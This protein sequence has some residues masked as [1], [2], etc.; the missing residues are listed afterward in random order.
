MFEF[1]PDASAQIVRTRSAENQT[2]TTT[3]QRQPDSGDEG[4]WDIG[5]MFLEFLGFLGTLIVVVI[6]TY[7]FL[8]LVRFAF[9]LYAAKDLVYLKVTLPRADSKLDK[10]RETK[11]DFKE[12]VGIMSIVYKGLHKISAITF[13]ETIM[14]F[15]FQHSKMSLELV[16][17]EGQVHFFVVSYRSY[18][19]II[20]QQVT[21][22]YPDAEVRE[23]P[24]EKYFH[25]KPRGYTL[26]AA[27]VAKEYDDIYPIK[28]F[29]YF[30]DDPLSSFTNAFGGLNPGDKAVVQI[31]LKPV[32]ASWNRHA[33]AAAGLVAKGNYKKGYGNI[34][35]V[36]GTI[37]AP[38]YW[39]MQFFVDSEGAMQSMSS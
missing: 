24:K 32:G 23:I 21:A 10:E 26:R 14:D 3:E 7:V 13:F 4:S 16:Y 2:G 34:W 6:A 22:N 38:V 35:N 31:V 27:S 29:K 20:V 8:K 1:I 11:K 17:D 19:S 18:R 15:I 5:G 12:K 39:I 37:F 28:T 33:K 30:E 9:E 36:I 25:L